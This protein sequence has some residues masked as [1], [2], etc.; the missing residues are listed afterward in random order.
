M[1]KNKII[2]NCCFFIPAREG[3]KGVRFKNRKLLSYTVDSIPKEYRHLVY[4]STDDEVLKKQANDFGIN[5]VD[6]P[7]ELATDTSSVLKM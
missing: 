4:I 2:N 5:V 1:S 6:R 3:S 7:K